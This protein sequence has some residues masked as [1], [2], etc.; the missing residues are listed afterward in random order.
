[1][2]EPQIYKEPEHIIDAILSDLV[3]YENPQLL[4]PEFQQI[5]G[6]LTPNMGLLKKHFSSL[7]T[8]RSAWQKVLRY[9]VY[10]SEFY[11]MSQNIPVFEALNHHV[12]GYLQ[13]MTTLKNK[14]EVWLGE[15][16]NDAKKEFENKE[17]IME[18]YNAAVEKT[19]EVFGGVTRLRDDHHHRGPRFLDSDIFKAETAHFTSG[20]I[21]NPKFPLPLNQGAIPDILAKLQ[22]NKSEAFETAKERWIKTARENGEQTTGYLDS[23]L[24]LIR[25]NLCHLLGIKPM[26]EIFEKGASR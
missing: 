3:I 14:I 19:Q 17:D 1:M 13:D 12:H 24:T 8:V 26:K 16:K 10:F 21:S 11:P 6:K 18:F 5:L 9:E 20:L 2:N 25:P 15:F 22:K 23:V 7:S 4:R